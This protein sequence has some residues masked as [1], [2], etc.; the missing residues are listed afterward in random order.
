MRHYQSV[1]CLNAKAATGVGNAIN[2]QDYRHVIIQLAT[3]SSANLTVKVAGSGS[4]SAPDFG[5]AASVSN[6]WTYLESYDNADTSAAIAGATGIVAT[7]T[8]IVKTI[9][10]NT[11]GI[12]WINLNVTARSA[13]SVTAYVVGYTNE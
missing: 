12:S 10:V 5:S 8:D 3:A 1:T 7:G 11:D 6:H 9:V 13:G 2:V 4:L